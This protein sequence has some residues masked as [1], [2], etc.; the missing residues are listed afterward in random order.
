[1]ICTETLELITN[2]YDADYTVTAADDDWQRP[3]REH[4]PSLRRTR[5]QQAIKKWSKNVTKVQIVFPY[6]HA[7]LKSSWF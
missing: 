4:S 5:I 7:T 3:E 6:F 1:M 2:A